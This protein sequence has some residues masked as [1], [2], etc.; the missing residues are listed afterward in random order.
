M[1]TIRIDSINPDFFIRS[2][3]IK[4]SVLTIEYHNVLKAVI[5]N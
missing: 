1:K 2:D 3:G 5:G 4:L